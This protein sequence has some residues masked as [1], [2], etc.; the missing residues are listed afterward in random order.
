M[1]GKNGLAGFFPVVGLKRVNENAIAK[2]QAAVLIRWLNVETDPNGILI[3]VEVET[4]ARFPGV[5]ENE[6]R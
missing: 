5:T 1:K 4:V 2:F 3:G 6:T